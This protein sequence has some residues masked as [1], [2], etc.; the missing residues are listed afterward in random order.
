M[1]DILNYDSHALFN[2]MLF[3]FRDDNGSCQFLLS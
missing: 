3:S 2:L 1:D